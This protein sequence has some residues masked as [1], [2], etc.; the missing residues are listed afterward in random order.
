MIGA[1]DGGM[2]SMKER[3]ISQVICQFLIRPANQ[4]DWGAIDSIAPEREKSVKLKLKKWEVGGGEGKVISGTH[5][6]FPRLA[7]CDWGST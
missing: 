2:W 3:V 6:S 1:R 7:G 5:E 4:P